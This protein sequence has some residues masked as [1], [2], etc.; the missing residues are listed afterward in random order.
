MPRY[1]RDCGADFD[2]MDFV[3]SMLDGYGGGGGGGGGGGEEL[4]DPAIVAE[5]GEA[6]YK[7]KNLEAERRRRSKLNNKLFTL[8]SLVPNIT[9]ANYPFT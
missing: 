2:A 7:S 1:L 8:R 3:D 9:K 6:R 4:G 5:T